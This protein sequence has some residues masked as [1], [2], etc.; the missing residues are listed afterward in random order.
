MQTIIR[1][2]EPK[3]AKGWIE[4]HFSAVH[5]L[6]IRDYSQDVCNQWS[7]PVDDRRVQKVLNTGQDS[8]RFVADLD[9]QIVGLAEY[10]KD[11][12][13]LRAC[14]VHGGYSGKGIGEML[15]RA[16]EDDAIKNGVYFLQL[17]SSVTAM[18]FYVKMGYHVIQEDMHTLSSGLKIKCFKMKKI[19]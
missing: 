17:D 9:S 7:P 14:Y 6:G 16:I 13:E 15:I 1:Q 2:F 19:L 18:P 8:F 12:N 11:W 4:C 5:S 3:D 10:V